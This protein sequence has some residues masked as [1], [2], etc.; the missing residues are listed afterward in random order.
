MKWK[1]SSGMHDTLT[2]IKK[3]ILILHDLQFVMLNAVFQHIFCEHQG[4]NLHDFFL[5]LI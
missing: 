5:F 1:E 2:F 3:K 4:T